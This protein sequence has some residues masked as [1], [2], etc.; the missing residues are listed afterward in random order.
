[1]KVAVIG[2]NGQLGNDLV[3]VFKKTHDVSC[4]TH[5]D[6]DVADME[7]SRNILGMLK[8]DVVLNTAAAHNVPKCEEDPATAYFV[9][10]I[11][12]LNLAKISNEYKFVLVHYSTD[13]IFDGTKDSPYVENDVPNPLNV[14]GNTKL[15]GENFVKN[16]AEQGYVVRI[17]GIYGKARCRAKGGNFITTMIRLAS[18]KSEVRVVVDEILT[19]TST[20]DIA[21][22]TKLL[23][24][25][26][27]EFGIY[28]MTSEGACSWYEF[29]EE[30]FSILGL[31]TPLHKTTIKEMPATVK[32][33]FNSVL[34][35]DRLK[36]VDLNCMPHWKYSLNKFMENFI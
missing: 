7:Q 9:N 14:Y 6:I 4:L 32:R 11:G 5:D 18:E 33:P 15:A 36:K 25:N 35:N 12:A 31:S 17:S 10:G 26:R 19:P 16:Y 20:Y 1:M 30:I 21:V 22:N 24:E 3:E 2:S 28:H 13:Y 29:A 23:L 34:E 27:P 8:P